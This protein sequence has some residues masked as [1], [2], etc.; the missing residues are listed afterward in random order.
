MSGRLTLKEI[1]LGTCKAPAP[2]EAREAGSAAVLFGVFRE[3]P[4][5]SLLATEGFLQ[6][7]VEAHQFT[8][9]LV[10][11]KYGDLLLNDSLHPF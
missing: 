7:L 10:L 9:A 2:C 8:L 5:R 6:I 1:Q 3:R 4:K 11:V